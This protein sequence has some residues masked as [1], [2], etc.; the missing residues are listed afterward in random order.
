MLRTCRNICGVSESQPSYNL[1]WE[2]RSDVE[3]IYTDCVVCVK[4]DEAE[5]TVEH[6]YIVRYIRTG[7]KTYDGRN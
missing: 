4:R 6:E 7:Y 3:E 2:L 1:L 5:E